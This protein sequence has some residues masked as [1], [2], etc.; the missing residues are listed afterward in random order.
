MEYDRTL[1]AAELMQE[2]GFTR[3]EASKFLVRFGHSAGYHKAKKIGWRELMFLQLD[4]TLAEWVKKNC[5]EGRRTV[6]E[7]KG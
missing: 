6:A 4:G 1:S 7:R 5:P 3:W 2:M